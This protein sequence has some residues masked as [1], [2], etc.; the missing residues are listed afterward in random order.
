METKMGISVLFAKKWVDWM[1][2]I[3]WFDIRYPNRPCQ[4]QSFS[5]TSEDLLT[6]DNLEG[7][8]IT[9]HSND[10][11]F[12]KNWVTNSSP[13]VLI[14]T[15]LIQN[16]YKL[17]SIGETSKPTSLSFSTSSFIFWISFSSL[18][19]AAGDPCPIYRSSLELIKKKR[20]QFLE[21]FFFCFGANPNLFSLKN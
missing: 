21:F 17:S 6:T 14:E 3:A 11:W 9:K 4:C 10:T 1:C 8:Q 18:L 7:N 2:L 16:I 5:C 20:L 19:V 15:E 12:Q 13:I